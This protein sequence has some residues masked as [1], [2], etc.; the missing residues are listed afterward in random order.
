MD[1]RRGTHGVWEEMSKILANDE[2][3]LSVI[4]ALEKVDTL[5]SEGLE[6]KRLR[7]PYSSARPISLNGKWN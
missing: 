2:A 3:L 7:A 4:D 5:D 6:R 1:K